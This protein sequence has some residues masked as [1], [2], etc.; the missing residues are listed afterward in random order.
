MHFRRF[1]QMESNARGNATYMRKTS[2]LGCSGHRS[3]EER[4]ICL[5][6]T[7]ERIESILLECLRQ[8]KSRKP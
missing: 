3:F 2:S 6:N 7:D 5:D 8:G 4:R 1:G